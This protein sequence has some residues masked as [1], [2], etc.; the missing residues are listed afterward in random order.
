MPSLVHLA[1]GRAH[2]IVRKLTSIGR[3][4]DNDI[5]VDDDAVAETHAHVR[6]DGGRFMLVTLSRNH[7]VLVNGRKVRK[8]VLEHGDEVEVG[9]TLLRFNLWDEPST[10]EVQT[11]AHGDELGA[12][13]RLAEFTQRLA[14]RVEVDQLLE[15]LLDEVVALTGADKGFLLTVDGDHRHVRTA[16]NLNRETI[17]A[18]VDQVSDSIID[19]VLRSRE[20]VIVSDALND[21]L[22]Q[23]SASVIQLELCSVM[24]VP[25]IFRGDLLGLIYLGNDNVVN[26]FEADTLDMLTV[27]A[28]QAAMLLQHALQRQALQN[29]N[30]RLRATLE[31]LKFGDIIGSC[32]AMLEVFA[33]VEKVATTNINV[34]VTGETGTG[35]E[36][37]AREI[38]RRSPRADGPFVAVNCG[39]I[40][41]NLLESEL[42][43]HRR[44]AFTGAVE[45]KMGSFQAADGGTLFLDEIGDLP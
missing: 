5:V 36:L 3:H 15:R 17:A 21:T 10:V 35:K 28:S 37:I 8:H 2:L 22:F 18:G 6:L 4:A 26:L 12:Y 33:K 25:L 14:E 44:G 30:E 1:R 27:F 39:A 42:F 45:H 43:G 24:C 11:E 7:P 41:E 34:L 20:P 16:R 23:A 31:G 9:S 38:H 13:R 19:R 29:D 40:P 32:D